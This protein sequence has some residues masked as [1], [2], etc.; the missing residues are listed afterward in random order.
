[1]YK[2]T[3]FIIPLFLALIGYGQL[4][5]DC[6]E[7]RIKFKDSPV[8]QGWI[9]ALPLNRFER[10]SSVFVYTDPSQGLGRQYFPKELDYF[11]VLGGDRYMPAL[12]FM[13]PSKVSGVIDSTSTRVDTSSVDKDFFCKVKV[14]GTYSLFSV[15]HINH[16]DYYIYID[17]DHVHVWND[18]GPTLDSCNEK[19][20]Y[21][22]GYDYK[23][24]LR[25]IA[26][27]FAF[28]PTW[29]YYLFNKINLSNIGDLESVIRDFNLAHAQSA[30]EQQQHVANVEDR[31]GLSLSLGGSQGYSQ[32]RYPDT[33][34]TL[35]AGAIS[36]LVAAI[37]IVDQEISNYM[38]RMRFQY[39]RT[40]HFYRGYRFDSQEVGPAMLCSWQHR[41]KQNMYF[42]IW[43]SFYRSEWSANT[44]KRLIDEGLLDSFEKRWMALQWRWGIIR[45]K[46]KWE[47]GLI[48]NLYSEMSL[49]INN[50]PTG[51]HLFVAK[52]LDFPLSKW[53]D[54]FDAWLPW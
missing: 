4:P 33:K 19:K 27:H 42:G 17:Y 44:K 24:Q 1:M 30:K 8:V 49:G 6:K 3:L 50:N 32:L 36:S 13:K 53:M 29:R 34:I 26:G 48:G 43:A 41:T 2:L 18:L 54:R 52:H 7:A 38:V 51:I 40:F 31:F 37:E 12:P 14:N 46:S 21:P 5:P 10:V 20:Q 28:S 15:G 11:E 16:D 23:A 22:A 39:G 45:K 35:A 25:G 9:G 47:F